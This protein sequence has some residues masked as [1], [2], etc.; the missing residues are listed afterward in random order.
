MKIF[1]EFLSGMKHFEELLSGVKHFEEFLSGM[2]H[3][4]EFLS[5]MKILEEFLIGVKNFEELFRIT[6]SRHILFIQ[7]NWVLTPEP[8]WTVRKIKVDYF[9]EIILI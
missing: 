9:V 6:S 5:G 8:F 2:K 1:E 3:L 4:E 7:I